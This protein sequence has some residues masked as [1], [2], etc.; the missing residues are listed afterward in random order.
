MKQFFGARTKA[1]VASAEISEPGPHN[2]P[3]I[4]G[5]FALLNLSPQ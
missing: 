1:G 5:S 4:T 3:C 2:P